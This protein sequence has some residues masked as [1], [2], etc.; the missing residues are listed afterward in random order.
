MLAA[1]KWGAIVGVAAYVVGIAL[2]FFNQA[3]TA[4]GSTSIT[5][6]PI[7]LV[8]VCLGIFVLLFAASAAGFYAGRETGI[9]GLG[10]VAGIIFFVV[11]DLLGLIYTPGG[12]AGVSASPFWSQFV[13]IA[14]DL[15]I[16]ACMGWLGGR[17]G[18]QRSPLRAAQPASAPRLESLLESPPREG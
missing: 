6:N 5:E 13:A 17:P 3:L 7:L 1:L 2:V 18:A 4:T 9:A 16:V 14:F 10:A 12:H 11:S 15:G 8:P